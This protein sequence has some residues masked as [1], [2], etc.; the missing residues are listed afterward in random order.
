MATVK[1][2]A[3]NLTLN[4]DGANN[5]I[6]F[7][8]NGS[9]VATLDQA[10]TFT[11]TSFAGSGANL[12]GIT[13]T[14]S[15]K[16]PLAGGTL[17]G[18]TNLTINQAANTQFSIVNN[19]GNAAA[20][21]S[22]K[23]QTGGGSS[24]DPFIH[25]NNEIRNISIGI[26]N[27]DSDKFKISDNATLG[28]NDRFV[29]NSAGNVGIGQTSPSSAS[30]TPL[31]LHIGNSSTTYCGIV[32]E[33]DEQKWE[34][35]HNGDIAFREGTTAHFRVGSTLTQVGSTDFQVTSGDARVGM[36]S[37]TETVSTNAAMYF[38]PTGSSN[39]YASLY[40][41]HNS[42]QKHGIVMKD[43]H[44]S[45]G[46][47]LDFRNSSGTQVGSIATTNSATAYNTSSDYRLKE[48]VDY[49]WDATTRLK[50]LKPARFNWIV[51]DTN[52]LVDGFIAH[53]VS[54][55]VPEAISGTK[56]A[57]VDQEYEIT[58]A[59]KDEEG[60]IVTE[61]VMGTRTVP[62]HQGIDQSKLVPL[63]VKTIQ[64]ME[65]RITALEA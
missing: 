49:T 33:D 31:I 23:V 7:Q 18:A 19:T 12:T 55:I 64:E 9:N 45:C 48:N 29:I 63:L 46:P 25:L 34:I 13:H 3:E 59:V 21:S 27:S 65:A 47:Q 16:L 36:T 4:A 52:T 10:G 58:P 8:S 11:A 2:S 17:T 39:E 53:E 22:L 54:G 43:M 37:R 35:Q 57:M 20:A 41:V 42:A 30:S 1:S 5:D 15:S 50:Q 60:N 38:A 44:S 6:I 26:D 24:G 51:D 62:D 32:L 14:D 56:D 40:I 28:T 61:A